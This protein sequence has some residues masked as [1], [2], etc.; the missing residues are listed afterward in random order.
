MPTVLRICAKQTEKH[1]THK[2]NLRALFSLLVLLLFGVLEERIKAADATA[3][4]QQS[5][6]GDL[7]PYSADGTTWVCDGSTLVDGGDTHA[8]TPLVGS[9]NTTPLYKRPRGFWHGLIS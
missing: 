7:S 3:S 9:N 5:C 1:H 6:G 4:N 8:R 2:L